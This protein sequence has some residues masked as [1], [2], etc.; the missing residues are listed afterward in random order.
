MTKIPNGFNGAGKTYRLMA[1]SAR[2]F[3]KLAQN[4][5]LIKM[6]WNEQKLADLDTRLRNVLKNFKRITKNRFQFDIALILES[7]EIEEAILQETQAGGLIF[8]YLDGPPKKLFEHGPYSVGIKLAEFMLEKEKK[9]GAPFLRDFTNAGLVKQQLID[10]GIKN[11][12][13]SFKTARE[14]SIGA[15]YIRELF[16]ELITTGFEK[17]DKLIV[18]FALIDEH[19]IPKAPVEK[20]IHAGIEQ[21]KDL[22]EAAREFK[23]EIHSWAIIATLALSSVIAE[24]AGITEFE[25]ECKDFLSGNLAHDLALGELRWLFSTD[26]DQYYKDRL[27]WVD[28]QLKQ[29][30]QGLH[31]LYDLFQN[32]F[33]LHYET[34]EIVRG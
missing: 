12:L 2:P 15:D 14:I 33:D 4:P 8:V 22:T 17:L 7:P 10:Q 26:L 34:R 19:P 6:G 18:A 28:D 1:P 11:I 16:D 27:F 5:A 13:D 25:K 9:D 20:S 21:L 24:K 30:I 29:S 31:F 32:L 3:K 23:N